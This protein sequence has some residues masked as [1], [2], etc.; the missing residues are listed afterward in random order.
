LLNRNGASFAVSE[1]PTEKLTHPENHTLPG[2]K[3]V[4][5]NALLRKYTALSSIPG[6]TALL[7]SPVMTKQ[8]EE[9]TLPKPCFAEGRFCG[10]LPR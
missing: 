3:D 7:V 5:L 6:W 8:S 10:W 9:P 4:D 1:E 2:P